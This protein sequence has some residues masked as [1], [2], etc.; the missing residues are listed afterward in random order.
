MLKYILFSFLTLPIQNVRQINNVVRMN[1]VDIEF[2]QD[3]N[4]IVT[5]IGAIGYFLPKLLRN[6]E[7][8]DV[9]DDCPLI[10]RC[11]EIGKTKY[12]CTPNN[13]VKMELSYLTEP[14][15]EKQ[16]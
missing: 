7:I 12:C 6:N 4:Y 8:C 16:F 1:N 15:K 5:T 11:C 3:L 10:M 9:D 14:V 2:N 13:F